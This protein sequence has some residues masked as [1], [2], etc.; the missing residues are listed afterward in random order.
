MTRGRAF[1]DEPGAIAAIEAAKDADRRADG[2]VACAGP[3]CQEWLRPEQVVTRV[4]GDSYGPCC[5]VICAKVDADLIEAVCQTLTTR[6]RVLG[7]RVNAGAITTSDLASWAVTVAA[8]GAVHFAAHDAFEA[9]RR[10]CLIESG[11]A[12]YFDLSAPTEFHPTDEQV[13]EWN[14]EERTMHVRR[15]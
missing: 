6:G 12:D 15:D 13:A 8:T 7:R 4:A 5:A 10:Y 2:L 9:A 14:F 3:Y 1:D 11:Q